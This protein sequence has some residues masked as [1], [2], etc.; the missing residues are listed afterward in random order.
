MATHEAIDL[1]GID[2]FLIDLDGVIYTGTTPIP[3]GAETLTLLDQL[4]YRVVFLSNST[5]RSRDS[6][7]AKLQSMGITVDHSSIFTPPVAAVALIEEEGG[8]R[9][10]LFTTGDVHLDFASPAIEIL[11]SGRVDYVVVGD[12]GDRWTNALLTDA[13]RCVQDGARL[14]ALEKDRYW[15]GSDG[16]RLSAG[17][18][19]AAIEYATGA[20]ATVLG[21]PSSQYFH[22]ALQTL[23]VSPG[24]AAMIGDD[25]TTDIGG[26]QQ[27]GLKGIQVRT[28]K[29][30]EEA[31]RQ[32]GITPDLLIDSLASLQTILR[33]G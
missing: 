26:A 10:R 5:Q 13:F 8:G 25:I 27:A 11:P 7:R 2:A 28:G 16:L 1:D 9:C 23:G 3:G 17:P 32:S 15:M 20:T 14:L 18:F 12:A 6:I 30:R 4:G 29:Y 19:V 21:K 33:R 22:R 24:R 31:V